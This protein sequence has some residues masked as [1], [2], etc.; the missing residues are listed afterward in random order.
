MGLIW[1][2]GFVPLLPSRIVGAAPVALFRFNECC[3]EEDSARIVA[4]VDTIVEC[5]ADEG[6]VMGIG[7]LGS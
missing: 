3:G 2:D 1:A 4:W 5:T 7:A 6:Y